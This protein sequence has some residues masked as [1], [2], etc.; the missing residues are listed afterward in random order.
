MAK[1][2][3]NEGRVVGLS[4][5][6][7]YVKNALGD[8]VLPE[9]IPDERHWLSNMIGSGASMILK[10]PT[11][12]TEGVH[13]YVLPSGS[14]LAAAGVIV[15]S[16][17]LGECAWDTDTGS[18]ATK[19]TSYS[20]LILNEPG[21]DK[22]PSA[23]GSIVPYS[24]T[25]SNL[26]YASAVAEFVKITDGIVFTRNAKWIPTG[27]VP[28]KDINPNFNDSAAVVRLYINSDVNYDI[29]ILLT[30]FTNKR[31]LQGLSGYARAEGGVSVGGSTD[32]TNNHWENG[33][34]LG[35]EIMPW[36][37]KIIFT[38]PSST[39]N[40][41]NSLTR[42]IPS[43]DEYEAKTI[44]GFVFKDVTATVKA[45]S[46]IDLN[47]ID[48]TDYYTQ[49][50]FNTSPTLV[51]NVTK[52]ALGLNDSYNSLVAWY[53]GMTAAQIKA[54]ATDDSSKIFPP[55]LYAAQ[56]TATGSQTLVPLDVAAPGTVK[57]FDDPTVAYNYKTQMPNNYAVYHNTVN[58]TFSYVIQG[59]SDPTHWSGSAKIE[60]LTGDY[61]IVTVT[62]GSVK[63]KAISLTA[64]DF[65]DYSLTGANGIETAE[66]GPTN[67]LSWAAMLKALKSGKKMNVLGN[68]LKAVGTELE[69]NNKIGI[70]T[71]NDAIA[72]IGA[73]K[74]T[75]NPGATGVGIT[76]TTSNNSNVATLDNGTSIKVGT[77]FIEFSNG[78]R[79][80]ISMT[81]P[82]N[83]NVPDGSIG[84][85]W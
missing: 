37:S 2:I 49:H 35:P 44:D 58:N 39:Y 43:D 63:S 17:F 10:V 30:G 54:T 24:D 29:Y 14:E 81:D 83:T 48:I 59:D 11:G 32:T 46:F 26:T 51:E 13:D 1:E 56:V 69:T 21:Q 64:S 16:P 79:L 76:T 61:P 74:V 45:N 72:E 34:M 85:G 23:D 77:N 18:W 82:G 66:F 7:I 84:I 50:T 41:A 3:Y 52:L 47:S 8:G 19:V 38:V 9:N 33:G 78:K 5:W 15:A 75:I 22:S 62:A 31:I 6:E 80:Y 71:T 60:Y 65:T 70:D 12:T 25:Y 53:P 20:P 42:T 67:Y 27:N 55:A 68:R 40:L 4:A 28:E 36:A 73:T 57:G